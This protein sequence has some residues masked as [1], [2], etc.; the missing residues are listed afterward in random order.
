MSLSNCKELFGNVFLTSAPPPLYIESSEV[1]RILK[2]EEDSHINVNSIIAFADKLKDIQRNKQWSKGREFCQW[3]QACFWFVLIA[4]FGTLMFAAIERTEWDDFIAENE[5]SKALIESS[6]PIMDRVDE[7]ITV[8]ENTGGHNDLVFDIRNMYTNYSNTSLWDKVEIFTM[9][10]SFFQ[11]PWDFSGGLYFCFSIATTIGYGNFAPMT[12]IG[13]ALVIPYSIFAIL[14]LLWFLKQNMSIFR[15]Y[16]YTDCNNVLLS[17]GLTVLI[18]VAYL[19]LSGLVY[20]SLED[21]WSYMESIYFSWVTTSTIGFGDYFPD[22]NSSSI[23]G[24]LFMLFI[25]LQFL[26]YLSDTVGCL[27]HWFDVD[28]SDDWSEEV[29][30]DLLQTKE[31]EPDSG[32]EMTGDIVGEGN[33][34][35]EIQED[36]LQKEQE[37]AIEVTE[38][39]G[40]VN[41]VKEVSEDKSQKVPETTEDIIGEV[42]DGKEFVV[43]KHESKRDYNIEI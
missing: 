31:P 16:C 19:A 40:E 9:E 30:E 21:E 34:A 10:P 4:I 8:L 36:V 15:H 32:I 1:S 11:N 29:P 27:I 23:V 43:V 17:T 38:D 24:Y 14:S 42:N 5:E 26:T 6:L 22:H 7:I 12:D 3:F 41:D 20:V 18:L 28:E 35:E 2:L 37:S 33:S 39:I 25:A 13:K